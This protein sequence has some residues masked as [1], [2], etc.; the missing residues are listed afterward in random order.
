MD[1][2]DFS[3]VLPCYN[4]AEIF[5]DSLE[6]IISILDSTNYTWEIIFVEDCSKD[7][8]KKLIMNALK[9]F[10]R[11]NLSAYY[12]FKNLGRGATVKD[13]LLRAKGKIIGFIDID[14]EIGEWYIPKFIQEIEKGYAMAV[15]LRVYDF[16]FKI[17][18]M[19]RWI[20]SKL[21]N[22]LRK[23]IIGL[24]Y[25]DTEAG[26][27][28][29]N[30]KKCLSIIKKTSNKTWFWDTEVMAL[31]FKHNLKVMEIPVAFVRRSDKTSTVKLIPDTFKYL[32]DLFIYKWHQK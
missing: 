26:Y 8:T 23:I 20:S 27:K 4:E 24:P 18:P 19:L 31:A 12:H 22:L 1:K 10:K 11:K 7:I 28:F 15:A 17:K 3:L 30:K 6:R 13:G 25:Q 2:Y 29:F 16:S 21:Y 14:L 32:R 9:K 5:K